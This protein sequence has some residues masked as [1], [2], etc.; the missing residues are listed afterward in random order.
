MTRPGLRY[1][2][3]N[4]D[5]TMLLHAALW[6][7]MFATADGVAELCWP[8]LVAIWPVLLTIGLLTLVSP[9]PAWVLVTRASRR[10]RQDQVLHTKKL[11]LSRIRTPRTGKGNHRTTSGANDFAKSFVVSGY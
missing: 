5:V 8:R 9:L 11:H 7:A 4:N 6:V 2:F 10:R 1:L 3:V